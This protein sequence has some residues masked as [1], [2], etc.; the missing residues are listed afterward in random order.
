M[1]RLY[2]TQNWNALPAVMAYSDSRRLLLRRMSSVV[3]YVSHRNLNHGVTSS[4][5]VRSCTT[6]TIF[7]K[8]HQCAVIYLH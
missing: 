7:V 5:S 6:M 4:R 1:V 8:M 2:V 3:R